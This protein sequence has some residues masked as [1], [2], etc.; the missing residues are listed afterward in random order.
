M[1]RQGA[2]HDGLMKIYSTP[3]QHRPAAHQNYWLGY[4]TM[5]TF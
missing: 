4:T 3:L 1:A 2:P 5:R